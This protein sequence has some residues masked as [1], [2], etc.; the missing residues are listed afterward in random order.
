[1]SY[2][3]TPIEDY[4]S[5]ENDANNWPLSVSTATSSSG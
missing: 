4:E 5:G 3:W 2:V 1:M